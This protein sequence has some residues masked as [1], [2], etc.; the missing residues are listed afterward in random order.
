MQ[1]ETK[2]MGRL[3]QYG[4]KWG[5]DVKNQMKRSDSDENEHLLVKKTTYL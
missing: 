5:S 2:E 4:L 3:Q 1:P